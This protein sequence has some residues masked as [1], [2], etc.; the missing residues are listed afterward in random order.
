MYVQAHGQQRGEATGKR[1]IDA[2]ITRRAV[3][4]LVSL[5]YGS[6]LATIAVPPSFVVA[7]APALGQSVGTAPDTSAIQSAFAA[8]AEPL[9]L[10][11]L[12]EPQVESLD[13]NL[14]AVTTTAAV[15]LDQRTTSTFFL[16]RTLVIAERADM[17]NQVVAQTDLR[18]D[19]WGIHV[20]LEYVD[21]FMPALDAFAGDTTGLAG[22]E[23]R[24]RA[25]FDSPRLEAY[26]AAQAEEQRSLLPNARLPLSH[27]TLAAQIE[28]QN[29]VETATVVLPDGTAQTYPAATLDLSTIFGGTG[30]GAALTYGCVQGCFNA[31]GF[32]IAIGTVL[33]IVA[34]AIACGVVCGLT[35]GVACLPCITGIVLGACGVA[36]VAL[37][38]VICIAHCINPNYN[39]PP[40]PTPLPCPG[41][42]T[43]DHHVTVDEILTMVNIVLGNADVSTC[44]VADAT[45]DGQV[46]VDELLLAINNAL[47]GCGG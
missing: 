38:I 4:I 35:A 13:I 10:R 9:G 33:C 8:E 1:P 36:A 14:S 45:G 27:S 32:Q 17:P 44:L 7:A 18:I 43:G 30:G 5:V 34:G 15:P 39:P 20:T 25:E 6:C 12:G 46:T 40:T 16:R 26:V 24:R 31:S 28:A 42:C 41:D 37:P 19:Y 3:R 2:R 47:G 21:R 29:Y 22:K 11:V 23:I